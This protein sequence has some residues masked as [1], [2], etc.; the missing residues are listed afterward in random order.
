MLDTQPLP[1]SA[2][3]GPLAPLP[4]TSASPLGVL[5]A[6]APALALAACGE[7]AT[8]L[9]A[10]GA[11]AKDTAQVTPPI[12]A[13]PTTP[14]QAARFLGQATMGVTMADI[15]KIQA[16][17]IDGWLTEQFAL[18]R[19]TTHWDWLT[20]KGYDAIGNIF[21]ENGFDNTLWNQLITEKGQLRQRVGMALLEILVASISAGLP[22][23]W[24]P[25]NMGAYVDVLMDNAFTTYDTILMKVSTSAAMGSYLTFLGNRKENTATGAVPDEN[26]ARELMQLFTIGLYELNMDGTLKLDGN[27]KPIETYKQDDVIGLARVFTGFVLDSANTSTSTSPAA[28]QRPMIQSPSVHE[29]RVKTFLGQSIVAGTAGMASLDRAI[30]EIIFKHP[31][32]P[33]FISKQLIQKLVTS[34]PTSYYVERVATVFAN[35]GAGVRGNM[36]AVIRAVLTDPEARAD[37]QLPDRDFGK[38]REPI[39]RLTHW[40][41]AFGATSASGNWNIGDTSSSASRLAQSPG[42]SPSVF[43][44]FRPGYVPAGSDVGRRG[45]VA[46]EFQITNEPSV[47]AYV[48]YMQGIVSANPTTTDVGSAYTDLIALAGNSQT[49]VDRLNLVLGS[50]QFTADLIAD[51]KGAVDAIGATTAAGLLTRVQT[52]VLIAMASPQYLTQR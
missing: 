2:A 33:P 37:K 35:D 11:D 21:N 32:V 47:I 26:Y 22:G 40:A 4:D 6:T 48:N 49:L 16:T 43:N 23:S 31:N 25:F 29:L 5:I 28:Y 38:L 8:T 17:G 7:G 39:M 15:A 19:T 18:P 50:G 52:A 13:R 36:K 14:V 9:S 41:R 51:I 30:R 10:T 1:E 34:N 12:S 20:S 27:G 45:L 42:R 44:F 24:R 3:P 46:P